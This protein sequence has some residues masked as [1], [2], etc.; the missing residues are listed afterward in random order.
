MAQRDVFYRLD[1]KSSF[2][3]KGAKLE[4]DELQL[5]S[6]KHVVAVIFNAKYDGIR[7]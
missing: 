1:V 7:T 4:L 2:I 5:A 6:V 3:I